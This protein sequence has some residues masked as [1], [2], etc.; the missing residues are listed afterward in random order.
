MA[1]ASDFF[2]RI[3][4]LLGT[5][6]RGLSFLRPTL[7]K[8]S[9][10]IILFFICIIVLVFTTHSSCEFSLEQNL[11]ATGESI[12]ATTTLTGLPFGSNAVLSFVASYLLAALAVFLHNRL[13]RSYFKES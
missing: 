11:T 1:S 12:C 3:L 13:D 8:I 4:A 2:Q 7:L 6:F 5:A 10:A 9:L